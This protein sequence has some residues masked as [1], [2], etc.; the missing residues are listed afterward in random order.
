MRQDEQPP[1]ANTLGIKVI[2]SEL[3][4]IETELLVRPELG[5]RNGNMH[6]GAAMAFADDLGGAGIAGKFGK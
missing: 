6:G 5:N 3:D 1:F 2:R 4:R